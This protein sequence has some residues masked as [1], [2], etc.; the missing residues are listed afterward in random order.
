M[1]EKP[2]HALF[3]PQTMNKNEIGLK[4][5][6]GFCDTDLSRWSSSQNKSHT[7]SFH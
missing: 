5:A 2:F 6:V 7:D 4:F 3:I 1:Y